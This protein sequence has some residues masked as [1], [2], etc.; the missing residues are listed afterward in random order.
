MVED[1]KLIKFYI[2][3]TK[4]ERKVLEVTSQG[5]NNKQVGKVLHLAT[6]TVA[7]YLTGIFS[8]LQNLEE[9]NHMK[10]NR[11]VLINLFSRFF[12]RNPE[13]SMHDD[14]QLR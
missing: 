1:K 4:R 9:L 7:Y 12:E 6:K 3:L 5:L 10:V 11:L 14:V 8:E 2:G 13:M